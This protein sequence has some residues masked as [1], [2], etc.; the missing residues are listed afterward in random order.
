MATMKAMNI[1]FSGS[2]SLCHQFWDL[3]SSAITIVVEEVIAVV[4]YLSLTKYVVTPDVVV[5]PL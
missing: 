3:S 1:S 2:S 4:C 5:E